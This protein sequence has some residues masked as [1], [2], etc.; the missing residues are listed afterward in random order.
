VGLVAASSAAKKPQSNLAIEEG[1][2]KKKAIG[3]S[4]LANR[5]LLEEKGGE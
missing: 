2:K 5:G 3:Q 4:R 1:K